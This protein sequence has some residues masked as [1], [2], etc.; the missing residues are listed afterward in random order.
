MDDLNKEM[1]DLE[2]KSKINE[3]KNRRSFESIRQDMYLLEDTVTSKVVMQLDPNISDLR[4]EIKDD[5]CTDLRQI[6]K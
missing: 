6:V 1:N 4:N 5:V 2:S 3:D